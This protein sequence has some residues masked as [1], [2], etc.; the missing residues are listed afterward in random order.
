MLGIGGERIAIAFLVLISL[1]VIVQLVIV[2]YL[3]SELQEKRPIMAIPSHLLN[4]GLEAKAEVGTEARVGKGDIPN[5]N[6]NSIKREENKHENHKSGV[7]N[8]VQLRDLEE[9]VQATS[10]LLNTGLE[11]EVGTEAR[12][13]KGDIPNGNDNSIKHENQKY[14]VLNDVQLIDLE[15][16]VQ[17][18]SHLLNNELEKVGAEAKIGKGDIPNGNDNS[19][20]REENKH[21]N[22]KSRVLSDFQLR[23]PEEILQAARVKQT[24]NDRVEFSPKADVVEMYGSSPVILGLERCE[25]FRR[26]VNP[27]DAYIG[28][29]GL[30]NTG[31]NLL[32]NLLKNNC[33]IPERMKKHGYLSRGIRMQPPWGKH[34]PVAYRHHHTAPSQHGV[35]PSHFFPACIIKDPYTWMN[36]MC[37]HPYE[38]RWAHNKRHCPNLVPLTKMDK[39]GANG[40][41]A[42]PVKV[43]YQKAEAGLHYSKANGTHHESLA[44]LW[45]DWYSQWVDATFPRLII[46]FEDLLYH[47]EEVVGQVCRCGGGVMGDKFIYTEAS[48]KEGQVIHKGGNG[49][50]K[51]LLSYGNKTNRVA[52][53]EDPDLEYAEKNL[54]R[55]MMEMFHYEYPVFQ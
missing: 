32:E 43:I 12:I 36:S 55:D 49:L 18:T 3:E 23:D 34:S 45:N 8:D 38:A 15:K 54:N 53:Y 24:K 5:G 27:E 39:L 40:G 33:H 29:A 20:K 14:G 2:E 1:S 11:T 10:R 16:I 37:R 26:N 21:K 35:N 47:A 46:R 44:G 9:I 17:A 41:N 6:D 22:Q 52:V 19:I 51:S 31:T 30:F 28:P 4:N 42:V 25:E 7:L 48:A 13:G 50:V